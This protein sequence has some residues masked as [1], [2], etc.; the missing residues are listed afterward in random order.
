MEDCNPSKCPMEPKLNLCKDEIGIPVNA[1]EYRRIIGSLRYLTHTR[2]DL[3]YSVGVVSRYMEL[4]KESHLKAVKQILR[5]ING[6]I[7]YGL[8]YCKGGDRGLLGFSD[9]SHGMDLDDRN[10]KGTTGME[11]ILSL[12]VLKSSELWHSPSVKLNL[13]L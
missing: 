4:P 12:G 2:P 8:V 10:R 5:Y 6:T 9:S 3:G 1:K 11:V 13:W 7:C